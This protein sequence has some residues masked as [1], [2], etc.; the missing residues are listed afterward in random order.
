MLLHAATIVVILQKFTLVFCHG[1]ADLL[2]QPLV[3]V[4]VALYL[5][6][7]HPILTAMTMT[8]L[9]MRKKSQVD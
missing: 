2:H 5:S 3:L 7:G 1:L 8:F 6:S 9:D 4:F